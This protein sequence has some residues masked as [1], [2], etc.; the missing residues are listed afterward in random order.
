MSFHS[1]TRE[2]E[3]A[4]ARRR[5]RESRRRRRHDDARPWSERSSESN[6]ASNHRRPRPNS[7][8]GRERRRTVC[9]RASCT[10]PGPR[11][12]RRRDCENRIPRR[13][14]LEGNTDYGRGRSAIPRCTG[15]GWEVSSRCLARRVWRWRD[16]EERA[17]CGTRWARV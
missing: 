5:R 11:T 8:D 7:F 4:R 12:T 13:A 17:I 9:A 1:S 10:A 15:C 6:R 2:V 3:R 14:R 16:D